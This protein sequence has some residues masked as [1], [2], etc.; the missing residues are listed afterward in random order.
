MKY[1]LILEYDS[2]TR[3]TTITDPDGE[4]TIGTGAM[5]L[6]GNN[7]EDGV[8][9]NS[10]MGDLRSVAEAFA[11]VAGDE[12]PRSKA[13]MSYIKERMARKHITSEDALKKF[14][15][16]TCECVGDGGCVC[17]NKKIYH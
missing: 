2:D 14:E 13:V 5:L 11:C 16:S 4:K 6:L 7:P 17:G 1:K 3:K 12:N 10:I 9:Y 8:C 15:G